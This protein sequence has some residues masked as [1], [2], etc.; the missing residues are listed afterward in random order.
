[1]KSSTVRSG[2]VFTVEEIELSVLR[3]APAR[4]LARRVLS[5]CHKKPQQLKWGLGGG[6]VWC[7]SIVL[8]NLHRLSFASDSNPYRMRIQP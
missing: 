1:M 8:Q 4:M 7:N 6:V 5:H 3:L 2:G